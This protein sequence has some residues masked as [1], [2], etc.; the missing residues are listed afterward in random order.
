M[1]FATKNKTKVVRYI[2]YNLGS[3]NKKNHINVKNH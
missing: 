3:P 2:E 1:K